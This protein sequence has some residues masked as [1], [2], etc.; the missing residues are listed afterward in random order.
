MVGVERWTGTT[1]ESVLPS[2]TD[3]QRNARRRL[4][5][6]AYAERTV[7]TIPRRRIVNLLMV[8]LTWLAALLATLP[9][10]FI[11]GYLIRAGA[12]SLSV[13]FFTRMPRP[14]GESGGGMANAIAGTVMLV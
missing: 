13:D 6:R 8:R 3:P 11:L 1:G 4:V 12:S 2:P 14:V 7:G 5:E 9:L 10:V